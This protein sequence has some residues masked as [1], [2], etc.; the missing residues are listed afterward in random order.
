MAKYSPEQLN[1]FSKEQLISLYSSLQAQMDQ[2]NK[3]MEALI[4]QIRLANQQRFGR[5]TEKL[6]Q[7]PGQMSLFNEAEMAADPNAHEPDGEEVVISIHRKKKKGKRKEDFKDLPREQHPHRLTDEQLDEFF[8]KGNWRRMSPEKFLRL[9]C[10]PAVYTVE[11]HEVDVAVGTGGDHQDEF[12]RGDRP[13]DLLRNSVVTPSLMAAVLNGKYTNALPLYRIEQEF[14]A[15]G[16]RISRQ[17]MANWTVRVSQKYLEAVWYRLSE[18]LLKQP[19]TQADE[20]TCQVIHDNNPDDPNDRKGAPGH[21]NYMWV[22]RSGQFNKDRPIVLYEYQRT[23]HHKY[24]Q[25]FYRNYEG[26]VETDGLQQY[27][28]LEKL[29][30]GFVNASCWVHGRRF[31]ADAVKAMGKENR[32]AAKYTVAGQAL[33]R[34]AEIYDIENELADLSAEERL[35]ERKEKIEPLV[36]DFFAW[37]KKILSDVTALP[38]GKTAEGL[39]YCVNQEKYLRVFLTN[40]D[41]PIDN[42][43]SERAIRPFTIGRKNWVIIDSIKGAKASAVIYSIVETA[44][45]NNLNVYYYLDY[46]LTELPKIAPEFTNKKGNIDRTKLAILTPLMPWS[47]QLP[48]RCHKPRR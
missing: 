48:E 39:N 11:E 29:I 22:H 9:R 8:G 14:Q 27:H 16:I 42:S 12:L 3:N 31:F 34:I 15:N 7:I 23:R 13:K 25:E 43:A 35:S 41:V 1:N 5:K 36:D 6:D 2:M 46:L 4:E 17:T 10:Q 30:P 38:K 40:G 37:A 19:V 18:E 45:L 20:T 44:K 32:T 21:K 24:P 47:D 26:I 33:T 28:M